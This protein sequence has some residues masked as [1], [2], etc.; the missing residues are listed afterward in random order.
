MY[1]IFVSQISNGH[2]VTFENEHA[3]RARFDSDPKSNTIHR[4]VEFK[5]T[6]V[7]IS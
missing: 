3:I 6:I 2:Y 4:I 1:I 5:A 7:L